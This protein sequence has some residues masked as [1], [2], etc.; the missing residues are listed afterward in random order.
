MPLK[1]W[2]KWTTDETFRRTISDCAPLHSLHSDRHGRTTT[3]L[4]SGPRCRAL[5][6]CTEAADW[7]IRERHEAARI[8]RHLVR[9]LRRTVS[10]DCPDS[11][12]ESLENR[13]TFHRT[14][15]GR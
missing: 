13:F 1:E 12:R 3:P 2:A 8:Q 15:E 7:R 10:A 5:D 4:A 11:R 6:G 14:A 9:R